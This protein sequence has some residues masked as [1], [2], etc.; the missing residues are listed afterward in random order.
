VLAEKQALE[1]TLKA[2]KSNSSLANEVV[3]SKALSSVIAAEQAATTTNTSRSASYSDLSDTDSA[4]AMRLSAAGN[5]K[6]LKE[7]D[8]EEK[9]AALTSNIQIIMENKSNMEAAYLAEKKK[10]RVCFFL[11]FLSTSLY[12]YQYAFC[13]CFFIERL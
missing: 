6:Q 13:L 3:K 8:Y 5:N 11:Y 7:A 9:I 12:Y 4:S 2:L 1:I 10:I